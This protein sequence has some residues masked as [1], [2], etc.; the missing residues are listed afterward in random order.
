MRQLIIKELAKAKGVSMDEVARAAGYRQ[1][2]SL[3][4]KMARNGLTTKQLDGIAALLGV[5]PPQLYE[6]NIK[7][8]NCGHTFTVTIKTE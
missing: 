7:C 5:T 2:T 3:Y 6:N 8:P 4:Q 1:R